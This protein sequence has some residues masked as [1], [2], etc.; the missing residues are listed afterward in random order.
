MDKLYCWLKENDI[1]NWIG[2][3][4]TAIFWPLALYLWSKRKLSNIP[5]LT[6][7]LGKGNISI[8]NILIC[9]NN[10]DLLYLSNQ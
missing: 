9:L 3:I 8:P 7:S 5:N 6:V 4:F 10:S 2:L 1:P